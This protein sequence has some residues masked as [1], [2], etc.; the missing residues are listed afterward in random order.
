MKFLWCSTR[1]TQGSTQGRFYQTESFTASGYK[2]NWNKVSFYKSL[3]YLRLEPLTFNKK[4]VFVV[5]EDDKLIAKSIEIYKELPHIY[6]I[7]KGLSKTDK[8]LVDGLRK[9]K[10]GDEISYNYVEP[11]EIM[12]HLDLYAE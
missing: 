5:G 10:S 11:T 9:V 12:S 6:I 2:I 3:T 1:E 4:Y 7:S 8:I